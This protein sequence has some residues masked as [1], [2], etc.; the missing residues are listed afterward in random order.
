[1]PQAAL[2]SVKERL[3]LSGPE[4]MRRNATQELEGGINRIQQSSF[5]PD[6][7]LFYGLI[8]SKPP[9]WAPRKAP[10]I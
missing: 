1:V 6:F 2:H 9:F 10:P 4:G 3:I 5:V 7:K 8:R